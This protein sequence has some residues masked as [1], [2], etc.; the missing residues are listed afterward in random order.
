MIHKKVIHR[1]ID[2]VYHRDLLKNLVIFA[3]SISAVA[4]SLS[5]YI[6]LTIADLGFGKNGDMLKVH[7]LN[8]GQ[9]DAI[10]IQSPNRNSMLI[11]SGP[12]NE[13]VISEVQKF[14]N[15]FDR[16]INALLITHADADHI[17]SMKKVMEDFEYQVF[18][19]GGLKASTNLFKDLM[20]KVDSADNADRNKSIV[21]TAGMNIILDS[22]KNIKFEALFPDF[23][24]QIDAYKNCRE[25]LLA[26]EVAAKTQS[27][28]SKSN[29]KVSTASIKSVTKKK[30][31]ACLKSINTETNL[32]SIVGRLSYGSTSFM[33][34]GDAP[35]EVEQFIISKYKNQNHSSGVGATDI[36]SDVLK[37]G[38]HGSKTSTSPEFLEAVRPSYAIVSAGKDNRYGHPHKKVLDNIEAFRKSAFKNSHL[39]F[40]G[41]YRTDIDGT[42]S[43]YSDGETVN[44]VK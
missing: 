9:G 35:I 25:K 39:D 16:K 11:D 1:I 44:R 42:I 29:K 33:L 24:F 15:I 2:K 8:I 13:K 40:E 36:Q 28:I 19:H 6:L 41:I 4:L 43:F 22:E 14:K 26:K 23:D 34:T 32:N 27:K 21:L 17:G 18:M 3:V 10:Y 38:H 20:S 31:D 7:F 37:L 5:I 12:Q 30:K